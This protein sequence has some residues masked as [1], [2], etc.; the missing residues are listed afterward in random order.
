MSAAFY[1]GAEALF[2]LCGLSALGLIVW[3]F[4][5]YA[6]KAIDALLMEPRP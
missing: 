1:F 6:D 5:V 3:Q 2:T 4:R